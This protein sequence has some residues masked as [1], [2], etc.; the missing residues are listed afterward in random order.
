MCMTTLN[1][2]ANIALWVLQV[3][4]AAAF[5]MAAATKFTNYPPAVEGFDHIGFGRWFMYLIGAFEL[6]GAIGLLIP[7]LSGLAALGLVLLLIGAVI[8][9][10]LLFAPVTAL[11][12]AAYLIP[13]A[14]IAWSRRQRTSRF[15]RLARY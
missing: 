1:R 14:I 3:L 13:I 6:A 4:M 2:K 7:R 15:L 5:L 11:T 8:T 9:Q 12:P 10:L